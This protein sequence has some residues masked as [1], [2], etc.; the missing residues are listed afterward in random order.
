MQNE[1]KIKV[2]VDV[3]DVP[4]TKDV[5]KMNIDGLKIHSTDLSNPHLLKFISS[6]KLPL[7]LSTAGCYPN[8]IDEALQIL[9]KI[10][11]E[12]VLMHGFQGFPTRL[13]DSNLFRISEIKN[14]FGFPVGLMDH[15]SGSSKMASIIPLLGIALGAVVIEK[16][17]TLDRNKKR[18]RL[19]FCIKS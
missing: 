5:L 12:I 16:H 11:K 14:R 2:L 1:K 17:I 7:L 3:F 19:L 8:E 13:E 9:M 10:K 18:N 4:S 6:Q 15:I